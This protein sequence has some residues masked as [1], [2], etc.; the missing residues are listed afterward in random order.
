MQLQSLRGWH[1]VPNVDISHTPAAEK[2]KERIKGPHLD[3]ANK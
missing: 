1:Q 2:N 3:I